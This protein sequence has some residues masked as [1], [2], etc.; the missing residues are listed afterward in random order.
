[1]KTKTPI[2]Y[3][4]G[5]YDPVTPL[6][7]AYNASATFE[8]SV[9]LTHSGYGHGLFASPSK[10]AAAYTQAYFKNATLPPNGT[11]CEPDLTLL[12]A[13]KLA[14][15]KAAN[16]TANG[17]TSGTSAGG[18]GTAGGNNGTQNGSTSAMSN[19]SPPREGIAHVVTTVSLLAI[20]IWALA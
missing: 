6:V 15:A 12:Q 5:A 1:V 16:S 18:N 3:V 19:G 9:L 14:V 8:G 20:G 7:N 13:W 11:H 10:C 2:L 4:N 17:I